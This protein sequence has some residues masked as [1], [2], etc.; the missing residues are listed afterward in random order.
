MDVDLTTQKG[1]WKPHNKSSLLASYMFPRSSAT[2]LPVH[3]VAPLGT[4]VL[5]FSSRSVIRVCVLLIHEDEVATA[6]DE[7]VSVD[8][9]GD[10][11]FFHS[12]ETG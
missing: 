7:S 2:F 12:L 6:L 8:G 5:L 11:L 3:P 4:L 10:E 9:V 1:E